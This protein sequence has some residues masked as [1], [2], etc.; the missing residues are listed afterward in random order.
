MTVTHRRT[1]GVY[2]DDEN[3]V[4]LNGSD[5]FDVRTRWQLG[6]I[7]ASLSVNNLFDTQ[8][9]SLGFLLFDPALGANVR[10][11]YPAAGRFVSAQLVIPSDSF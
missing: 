5:V 4:R 8:Y 10:M 3:T 7:G 2:L 11:A 1:G 6:R 9:E